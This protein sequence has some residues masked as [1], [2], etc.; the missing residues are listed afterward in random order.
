MISRLPM[1]L[2]VTWVV[3]FVVRAIGLFI[4]LDRLPL[5]PAAPPEVMIN[6]PAVALGRGYGLAAFSFE[7]SV[8]GLNVLYAKF[9]PLYIALQA[10]VF[11]SLGVSAIT[12]RAPGALADL[13]ACAVFLLN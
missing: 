6:D 5:V 11:R 4:G 12:L 3:L 9:P 13:A 1:S 8:H 7:H 2:R 10:L